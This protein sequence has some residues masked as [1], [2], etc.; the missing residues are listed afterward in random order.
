MK[1]V[2]ESEVQR[3]KNLVLSKGTILK[4]TY[5]EYVSAYLSYISYF[6]NICET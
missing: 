2:R 1:K 5:F 6:N 3:I 4:T